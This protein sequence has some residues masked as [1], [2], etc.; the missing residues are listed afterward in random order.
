MRFIKK[1][2]ITDG[3]FG[4]LMPQ[5]LKSVFDYIALLFFRCAQFIL[6]KQ[7]ITVSICCLAEKVNK[8][9]TSDEIYFDL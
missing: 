4:D 9:L 3:L 2:E 5:D 6:G 1:Y 7:N 8:F